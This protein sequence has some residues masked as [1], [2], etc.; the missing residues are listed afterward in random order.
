VTATDVDAGTTL[1]YA[2]SGGVDQ[3]KFVINQTS[4][5][6]TFKTAPNFEPATD[7]GGNNVYDVTVQVA[8]G[9]SGLIDTQT[10]AVT[11][12]NV[13]EPPIITSNGGGSSAA[14]SINEN[15]TSVTTVTATDAD[16]G[17]TLSY[18]ISGGVDAAKFD[19]NAATGVLRFKTVPDHEAP[20]DSGGNNVYDVQV[21]ASDGT[22]ADTQNIAVTVTNL[23]DGAPAIVSNGGGAWATVT[24]VES[25]TAVTT[26]LATDPDA[27]TSLTY[28]ITGGADRSRFT[29]NKTTGAL[30]F[31][32]PPDFE[33]PKDVGGNN[34]YDVQVQVSDGSLSDTQSIAV[35]VVN[36]NE[37]PKITSNG[38][39]ASATFSV[40]EN[41]TTVAAIT[42]TDPDASTKLTFAVA[43][44]ADAAKFTIDATTGVLSFVNAANFEMPTDANFDN[45]YQVTVEVSDGLAAARQTLLVAVSDVAG[46]IIN[47]SKHRDTLRAAEVGESVVRGGN[48][49]D[50]LLG[51]E[52]DEHLDGGKGKDKLYGGSGWDVLDGGPGKDLLDGG[53]HG[54]AFRFTSKL[55]KANVDKVKLFSPYYD[56]IE[57]GIGVFPA[58]K[59]GAL[60]A[61][62]FHVG[63]KAADADDRIVYDLSSGALFYDRDGNGP[64]RQV[65]FA[66]LANKPEKLH[67]GDF[68][69]I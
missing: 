51:T 61:N 33:A 46:K 43:G 47:G 27:G 59:D 35:K 69:V 28:S 62:A 18:S 19:I 24:V 3:S 17:A 56:R 5:A 49:D 6:L 42:A 48:D 4:G 9:P 39:K 25:A 16:A 41:V 13:N 40:K 63:S 30:V 37:A 54:D 60:E 50:V 53:P 12:R 52:W 11:V 36:Q 22:F 21:R 7:S 66:V 31:V 20:G 23:S 65:K 68:L 57:L 58:L 38:G 45:R 44:G 29:I 14:I 8:D 26:I 67:D 15:T 2:I 1:S 34:I 55:G 64:A 32:A 10:I